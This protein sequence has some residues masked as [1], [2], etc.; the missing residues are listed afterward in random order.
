MTGVWI[1][2]P[3][4]GEPIGPIPADVKRRPGAAPHWRLVRD[5]SGMPVRMVFEFCDD[6]TC[7]APFPGQP[8]TD[9]PA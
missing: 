7:C 9:D 6:P 3:V 1:V 8:E 2:N 5:G 4:T